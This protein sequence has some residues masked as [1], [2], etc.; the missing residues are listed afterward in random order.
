MK[1]PNSPTPTFEPVRFTGDPVSTN[2]RTIIADKFG[3]LYLGTA[4]GVERYSP[5]TGLVKHF[6]VSDGLAAD[7]V[8]DSH[9]DRNGDLWFATNNGVSRL[10]PLPDEKPLPPQVF[11]GSLRISGEVQPGSELGSTS[12]ERGDL[13][14]TDN[15]FQ[16]DFF[17]LDMRA[18]EFLRYQYML[19]GADQEWSPPTDKTTVTYA[20]LQSGTYRFLVRAVNSDGIE[21]ERAATATFTILQPLWQRW[22]FL[23]LAALTVALIVA[24]LFK[25]RT[26]RLLEVNAALEEARRAEERLRRTREDRLM[27]LERVRSRIAT[28]LHDDIGASLTQIA[29]LSEVAQAG[30]TNG[31]SK[32]VEPLA[33]ISE[34]SNELVGTMSDIV[35]SIN[36]TKD[37]LRDL[38]Q[39][40]RRFYQICCRSGGRL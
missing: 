30:A 9:L 12:V 28:D 3:R 33:K 8:V 27:E 5:E 17:G 20:N 31:N 13:A 14:Y 34:V 23:L 39:R 15:N 22:W 7:F 1:D 29:I 24:L 25:Y 6:T 21:S 35:W 16:I 38:T 37:H 40:M 18:G 32:L 19:E 26:A 11:I 2:I 4:R 10:T 36:P